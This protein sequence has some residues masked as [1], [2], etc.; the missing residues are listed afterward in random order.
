MD[1]DDEA[2]AAE[3]MIGLASVHPPMEVLEELRR[4]SYFSLAVYGW[5]LDAMRHSQHCAYLTAPC[6]ACRLCLPGYLRK[7][8]SACCGAGQRAVCCVCGMA[9]PWCV[10]NPAAGADSPEGLLVE[11]PGRER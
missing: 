5:H 11:L 4:A 2:F 8:C 3:E 1:G 7:P 6:W 10:S 9:C